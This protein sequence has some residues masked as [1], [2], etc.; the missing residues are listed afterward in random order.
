MVADVLQQESGRQSIIIFRSTWAPLPPFH[1]CGLCMQESVSQTNV[2]FDITLLSLQKNTNLF[3]PKLHKQPKVKNCFRMDIIHSVA[4]LRKCV[5][6]WNSKKLGWFASF[7]PSKSSAVGNNFSSVRKY[8]L[9]WIVFCHLHL[10]QQDQFHSHANRKPP[11]PWIL[12]L[13]LLIWIPA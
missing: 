9:H 13:A 3:F 7:K 5:L 10:H 11:V 2:V 1:L 12:N 6:K 4:G 8:H